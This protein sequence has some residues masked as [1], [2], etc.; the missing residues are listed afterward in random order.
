MLFEQAEDD[1]YFEDYTWFLY[2]CGTCGGLNMYGDFFRVYQLNMNNLLDAKLYPKGSG[3]LPPSHMISPS[4]P[5]PSHIL[6][7]YEEVWPLRHR[8]PSAFIGQIRRLLEYICV[9][10]KASGKDLYGKLQDLITKGILPGYF[11]DITD[12]LRVVGNL[13]A[14]A[15]DKTLDIWDAELIDEFFRFVIEYVYVA[16]AKIKRMKERMRT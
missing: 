16:P 12:L 14:H 9:D 4:D 7:L 11:G 6:K 5:I 3:L 13:G 1:V 15:S 2:K 8:S 10:Q